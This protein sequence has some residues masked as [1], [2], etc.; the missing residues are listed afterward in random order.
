MRVHDLH[1]SSCSRPGAP[2]AWTGRRR[3]T[4]AV[5]RRGG[6]AGYLEMA[7]SLISTRLLKIISNRRAGNAKRPGKLPFPDFQG[8]FHGNEGWL[9][10]WTSR[11]AR[12]RVE[13]SSD[14]AP[15]VVSHPL[16]PAPPL[17]IVGRSDHPQ[18]RFTE[19]AMP[20]NRPIRGCSGG[21]QGRLAAAR[22]PL[23]KPSKAGIVLPRHTVLRCTHPH[24]R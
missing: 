8:H 6:H 11:A 24:D 18:Q 1:R 15:A 5:P 16:E 22:H 3:P 13:P 9:E 21:P 10:C 4:R 17:R 12:W 19:G 20:A 2:T 14:E 23:E 7:H